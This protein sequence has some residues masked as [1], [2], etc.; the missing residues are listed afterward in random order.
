MA[1]ASLAG[2]YPR[3]YRLTTSL[4]LLLTVVGVALG[5][6]GVALASIPAW[7]RAADGAPL[8]I[9]ALALGV[10]GLFMLAYVWR[11]HLVLNADTI[12]VHG[13]FGA[14]RLA[15][16]QIAGRRLL[17]VQ[18]GQRV[19]QLVPTEGARPLKLS[20]SYL[21]TDAVY[22]AWIDALPD[23]DA[24]DLQASEAAIE[25]NAELGNTPE[26][27]LARLA[28]ARQWAR[29][30]TLASWAVAAWGYVYP[31]PYTLAVLAL[32]LLPWVAIVFTA[33]SG[34]L[35]RF[36]TRRNDARPSLAMP[37]CVPGFVLLMRALQDFGMLDWP[38]AVCFAAVA[39]LAIGWAAL[40]S[41]TR[42]RAQP[43]VAVSVL[44]ALCAYGVGVV[45]TGNDL[46]DDR[47]GNDYRVEVL[48]RYMSRGGRSTSYHLVLAPWGP[49]RQPQAVSVTRP[50]YAA[51]PPGSSVC[52]HQGPGALGISWYVVRGCG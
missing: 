21:K 9:V 29:A 32:A 40:Q 5:A 33:R 43:A 42:A 11:W 49:R 30:L 15:R 2:D 46:L 16:A 31:R 38:R 26:E 50:L 19:L 22:A 24:L 52:I 14:R 36:D 51:V 39:A 4:R 20:P 3:T 13:L 8:L 6:G 12:E 35:Y 28:A 27:R 7:D 45:V 34:G 17:T 10:L 18:C 41:D 23:L 1:D 47:P 48:S 44:L 37:L 25:S